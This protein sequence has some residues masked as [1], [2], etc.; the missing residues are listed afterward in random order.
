[1]VAPKVTVNMDAV[2]EALRDLK[3]VATRSSGADLTPETLVTAGLSLRHRSDL[4]KAVTPLSDDTKGGHKGLPEGLRDLTPFWE[5]VKKCVHGLGAGLKMAR[6]SRAA[7]NELAPVLLGTP[8]WSLLRADL[9]WHTWDDLKALVEARWGLTAAQMRESFF[10]MR[11]ERGE[12]AEHFVLCVEDA[13]KHLDV[14]DETTLNV[15]LPCLPTALRAKLDDL[16]TL[17]AM[18]AGKGVVKVS[19]AMVVDACM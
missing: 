17:A 15:F 14:S 2:A 4:R 6:L 16:Q 12:P 19:W 5:E 9:S 1:M 10:R 7:V 13:R 3:E 11:P 8:I 18:M